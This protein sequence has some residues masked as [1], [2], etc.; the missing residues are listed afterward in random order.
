MIQEHPVGASCP[1]LTPKQLRIVSR[2]LRNADEDQRK[3]DAIAVLQRLRRTIGRGSEGRF[4]LD[5]ALIL[6]GKESWEL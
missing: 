3:Q 2:L 1:A 5:R 4:L 6:L